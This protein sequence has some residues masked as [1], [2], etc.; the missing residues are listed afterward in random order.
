MFGY[1]LHGQSFLILKKRRGG[2]VRGGAR[3]S[4]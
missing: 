1:I 4:S 3:G 2:E